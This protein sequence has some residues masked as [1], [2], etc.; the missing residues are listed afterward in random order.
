[1]TK[2]IKERTEIA[3]A[4]NGRSM[5]VVKL[6]I[7]QVDEYGLKSEPVVIDN[8]FFPKR[9]GEPEMPYMIESE[10]RIYSDEKRFTF[11]G[12]CVCLHASFGYSDVEKMLKYRNAPVI[13]KDSDI[14]IVP[15]NSRTREVYAP[16]TLHTGKRINAFCSTPLTFED[17]DTLLGE[18]Y[19]NKGREE[20]EANGKKYLGE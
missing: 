20:L 15:M 16:F 4:I 12:E 10:I 17:G 3:V 14:L 13:K 6:D 18:V 7:A 1:M 2:M 9:A 19:I 11:S 5:P 8:G